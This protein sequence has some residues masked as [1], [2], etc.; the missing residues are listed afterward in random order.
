MNRCL[1]FVDTLLNFSKD[2]CY[3]SCRKKKKTSKTIKTNR[4]IKK[5][6][7]KSNNKKMDA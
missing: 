5:K 6:K 4:V 7:T 1:Y 3:S 2:L